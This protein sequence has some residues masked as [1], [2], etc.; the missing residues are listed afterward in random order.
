MMQT[1]FDNFFFTATIIIVILNLV[2]ATLLEITSKHI[3]FV[4]LDVGQF[5]KSEQILAER[6]SFFG[7]DV[8]L[9]K[10]VLSSPPAGELTIC[11]RPNGTDF[12]KT[13]HVVKTRAALAP[14]VQGFG[15][16]SVGN[17]RLVSVG[18]FLPLT[19]RR[20]GSGS[21]TKQKA[22][23]GDAE[24]PLHKAYSSSCIT[25]RQFHG[26][27]KEDKKGAGEKF[28]TMQSLWWIPSSPLA[29]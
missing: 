5:D 8:L 4:Q 9:F 17:V 13:Q 23:S 1:V 28:L 2:T 20:N 18:S 16:C 26:R 15:Y 12:W 24:K 3:K 11:L 29:E 21:E 19:W 10:H 6:T 7:S 27:F 22:A 25:S 14:T